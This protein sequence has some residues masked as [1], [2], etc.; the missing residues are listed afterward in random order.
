MARLLLAVCMVLAL[1]SPVLA[2]EVTVIV[3]GYPFPTQ[4]SNVNWAVF[5]ARSI[6]HALRSA[7][8]PGSACAGTTSVAR[9]V[10][11]RFVPAMRCAS[12]T[13]AVA[14]WRPDGEPNTS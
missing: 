7:H 5:P 11:S 1:V 14:S 8:A 6:A 3:A 9:Y 12:P 13:T 2:E 10:P 4:S